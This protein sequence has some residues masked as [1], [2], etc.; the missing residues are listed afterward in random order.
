MTRSFDVTLIFEIW[1][2]TY[3]FHLIITL[4]RKPPLSGPSSMYADLASYLCF[5]TYARKIGKA[6]LIWW[7]N[8][9]QFEAW[10][11]HSPTQWAWSWLWHVTNCVGEWVEI[12]N[13]TLNH[14][15]LHR[16]GLPDF[17]LI[18]VCM[19]K[20]IGMPGYKRGYADQDAV[21]SVWFLPRS[22]QLSECKSW[23]LID[24]HVLYS[25]VFMI[26]CT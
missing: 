15:R 4:Q 17:S 19:L 16:V 1:L 24:C 8:W 20:N 13:H 25:W 10:S 12:C 18:H 23:R 22:I 11:A 7:C 5:S 14:V 26:F 9:M 2:V 21:L 6:W 3:C